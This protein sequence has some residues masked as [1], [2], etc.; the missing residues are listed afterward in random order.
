M[1]AEPWQ[2][3]ESFNT[4][5]GQG[6][7]LSTPLQLATMT[8]RL[9]NGGQTVAPRLY[10]RIGGVERERPA[11]EPLDFNTEHLAAMKEAMIDV[12]Y[13]EGGTARNIQVSTPALAIGGK[14]GTSQ[15]RRITMEEREEGIR[16]NEEL[17]W[18]FRDH[19][20]F[21]GFAPIEQPRFACAVVV[22]HGGSGS[23]VAAPICRDVLL[24]A[25]RRRPDRMSLTSL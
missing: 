14:T 1:Y 12:V 20:L 4:A 3:G 17:P 15:V 8:S 11:T 21:V 7:V 5:I 16:E 22:E 6:Y 9:I 23:Q 13:G 24:E 25:Q 2:L 10:R 18:R 19:A